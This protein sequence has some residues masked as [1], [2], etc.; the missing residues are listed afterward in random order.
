AVAVAL[1]I[2]LWDHALTIGDEI[3]LVWRQPWTFLQLLVMI[4]RYCGEA[5]LIFIAYTFLRTHI[6]TR[7]RAFGILVGAYCIIN[8]A[9]SQFA[10]LL[11]IYGLWDGR[12]VVKYALVIGF[13]I[14]FGI[15]LTFAVATLGQTLDSLRYLQIIN[16]CTT[17]AKL[18]SIV[19]VWGGMVLYDVYVFLL[20]L[21]NEFTRPHRR[22][23]DII[24]ALSRDGALTFLVRDIH[25]LYC[26]KCNPFEW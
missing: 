25:I 11:R 21:T 16:S 3:E 13:V 7:C 23:I 10:L 6:T 22:N 19:G 14:C 17:S 18:K 9:S 15:T 4:N 8:S 5:S 26:H 20:I 2:S 24:K 12:K 1:T